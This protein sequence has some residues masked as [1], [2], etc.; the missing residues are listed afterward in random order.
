MDWTARA[1]EARKFDSFD[2]HYWIGID[3]P[4]RN[5]FASVTIAAGNIVGNFI[6]PGTVARYAAEKYY[7][8]IGYRGDLP[9]LIF[10]SSDVGD[11]GRQ[12]NAAAL[13]CL[14]INFYSLATSGGRA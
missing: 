12:E 8:A 1:H 14:P 5:G 10:T 7:C 2:A 4:I 13:H 9:T 11:K 3:C 6:R